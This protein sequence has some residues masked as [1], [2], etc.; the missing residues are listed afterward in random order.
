[1]DRLRTLPWLVLL[2]LA[3]GCD[4]PPSRAPADVAAPRPLPE[5]LLEDERNT[6]DVFR[7]TSDSVVFVSNTEVVRGFFNL[8]ASE[9]P[10]GTGSGFVWDDEGRIVTNFH[11]I[12]GGNRFT[13]T[14]S[15]GTT[16]EA[17]LIGVA[18]RKDL[19]VLAIDPDGAVLRPLEIG[20]SDGLVVGQKVLAI[21]NPFGLDGS[22][23]T[24]VIS[25]LG[26]EIRSVAG[27]VIENVIQ[28]DASINPGNSGGPL[29]DSGG[30][31][32]GVTT[33]IFSTSGSSAGVGF[34]V[35]VATVRRLM[36]QLIEHGRVRWPGLGVTLLPD[37]LA[38]RWGVQGVVV[39]E[40]L[41]G[42]PAEAAGLQSIRAD[43]RGNVRS[44][45]LI[46]EAAGRRVLQAVDLLD[47][48][49]DFDVGD[50]VKVRF[51]RDGETWEANIRLAAL[52]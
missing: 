39:R 8:N 36:P 33:A 50:V 16:H 10:R 28:T 52:D 31:L 41:P 1:M 9:V 27:T 32:I 34:A 47:A 37:H 18:P 30:R 42:S 43:R 40:V 38:A 51:L 22:L 13:V 29:L 7:R 45:D 6:I 25:A 2:L 35:P 19:A 12:Q 15:D 44:F 11:V 49:D 14:L 46:V 48:L 3:L 26:R 23:S 24:G 4:A 21:G 20:D 17:K 5:N